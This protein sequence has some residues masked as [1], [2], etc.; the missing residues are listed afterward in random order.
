VPPVNVTRSYRYLLICVLAPVLLGG[1]EA[2]TRYDALSIFFDGCRR[3][4][5]IIADTRAAGA[6]GRDANDLKE[7]GSQH[8]VC[9][10]NMH[11]VS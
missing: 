4:K 9:R 7:R 3:L 8:G 1:C 10:E 2:Q 6:A 11:S 5:T